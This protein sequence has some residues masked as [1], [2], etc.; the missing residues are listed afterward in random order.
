MQQQQQYFND[1]TWQTHETQHKVKKTE[2]QTQKKKN[3]NK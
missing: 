3:L 1:E 2:K